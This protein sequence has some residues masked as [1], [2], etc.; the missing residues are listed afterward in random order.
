MSEQDLYSLVS[1]D[2]QEVDTLDALPEEPTKKHS[3]SSSST[4]SKHHDTAKKSSSKKTVKKEPSIWNRYSLKQVK[5]WDSAAVENWASHSHGGKLSADE[6]KA[7]TAA[8][9]K[10]H[11]SITPGKCL[12]TLTDAGKAAACGVPQGSAEKFAESV[13]KLTEKAAAV[14][15]QRFGRVILGRLMIKKEK[16]NVAHRSCVA[17]EIL[18][19]EEKYYEQLS[20]MI[21]LFYRPLQESKDILSQQEIREIFSDLEIIKS[22]SESFLIPLRERVST[23]DDRQKLGDVFLKIVNK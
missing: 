23:W 17:H 4:K 20:I 6:A 19:T 21:D 18:S 2:S 13:G 11:P 10:T 1:K 3:S 15:A 16:A 7:L 9:K 22:L 12:L 14:T 8:M 5:E